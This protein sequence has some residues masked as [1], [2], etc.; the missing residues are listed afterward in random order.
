MAAEVERAPV[1]LWGSDACVLMDVH[2]GI[3]RVQ[4]GGQRWESALSFTVPLSRLR[5]AVDALEACSRSNEQAAIEDMA[6]CSADVHPAL[7]Q[8]SG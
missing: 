7:D 6:A 1:R 8:E 5:L 3:V 4:V 2:A